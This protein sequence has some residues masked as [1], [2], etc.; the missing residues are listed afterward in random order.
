M[1]LGGDSPLFCLKMKHKKMN[2]D[3]FMAFFRNDEKLNTLSSEDRMEVFLQILQGS[4]DIT[5]DLLNEL[6]S[7]YNV[8]NLEVNHIK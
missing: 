2:R 6:I 5:K 1:Y 4:S 3:H 7:G 8:Y